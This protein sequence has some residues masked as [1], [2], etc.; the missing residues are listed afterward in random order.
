MGFEMNMASVV[1]ASML[2][3]GPIGLYASS[4]S[5]RAGLSRGG[6]GMHD[7]PSPPLNAANYGGSRL[8]SSQ[9]A[10]AEADAV[11]SLSSLMHGNV[12]RMTIASPMPQNAS[13]ASSSAASAPAINSTPSTRKRSR[14]RARSRS[15]RRG[16]ERGI[17]GR[18]PCKC[19]KS[20]CLKMY[21][22]CFASN[23][24]CESCNC[25]DC[26][27]S[28]AHAELRQSAISQILDRNPNAFSAKINRGEGGFH[29][30]GCHCKKSA[31]QKR[32]CECF[33]AGV[34]CG[35]YCKCIA[36]KNPKGQKEGS[37]STP[38]AEPAQ[39]KKKR[40]RAAVAPA[41]AAYAET[42]DAAREAAAERARGEPGLIPNCSCKRCTAG[43]PCAVSRFEKK[44]VIN[45]FGC[46]ADNDL[47]RSL[48]VSAT[49][50]VWGT[51]E[52]LWL[53][54]PAE[55]PAVAAAATSSSSTAAAK[56]TTTTSTSKKKKKKAPIKSMGTP[57]VDSPDTSESAAPLPG[58]LTASSIVS[59]PTGRRAPAP[60]AATVKRNSKKRKAA[61][62]QQQKGALCKEGA[63]ASDYYS[64]F[65]PTHSHT[66]THTNHHPPPTTALSHLQVASASHDEEQKTRR[67]ARQR[68]SRPSWRVAWSSTR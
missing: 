32:Y 42:T 64:P 61:G 12:G 57:Q 15:R 16:A 44:I 46:L 37:P 8:F 27:N 23:R 68:A 47:A 25:S 63:T 39:L 40:A 65:L 17:N 34:P 1:P 19:Q 13:P 30:K 21:C 48:S 33:Q 24:M 54:V 52:A 59:P 5:N 38:A 20:R 49:C 66:N 67:E 55:A 58:R 53:G 4:I 7:P 36:C 29:E 18:K 62:Q 6:R 3:G 51:D 35:Q 31:C 26:C 9:D 2:D 22:E 28:E 10:A 45:I 60:A 11:A 50:A 56:T 14:P 41:A 43:T